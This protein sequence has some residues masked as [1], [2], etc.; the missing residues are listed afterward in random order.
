MVLEQLVEFV[1]HSREVLDE[2]SIDITK[3]E[4]GKK[5]RFV[6]RG[7]GLL[8]RLDIHFVYLQAAWSNSV[9]KVFHFFLKKVALVDFKRDVGV[10]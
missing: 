2:P 10:R 3:S 7:F 1:I 5:L 9:A 4:E 6:L 8:Q